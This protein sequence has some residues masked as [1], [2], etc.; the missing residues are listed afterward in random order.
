MKLTGNVCALKKVCQMRTLGHVG[1]QE[2]TDFNAR[3]RVLQI[4]SSHSGSCRQLPHCTQSS[5]NVLADSAQ[6]TDDAE[7]DGSVFALPC[8][9]FWYP[10]VFSV[11]LST[12][13]VAAVPFLSSSL[14][15]LFFYFQ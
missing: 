6:V 12:S 4:S 1:G 2:C 5:S 15:A 8:F 7:A 14:T 13:S 10:D 11:L 3:V 9:L